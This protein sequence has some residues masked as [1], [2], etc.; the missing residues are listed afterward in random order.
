MGYLGWNY[1]GSPFS[2]DFTA[3]HLPLPLLTVFWV[4]FYNSSGF[5]RFCLFSFC[6]LVYGTTVTG[7]VDACRAYRTVSGTLRRHAA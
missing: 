5:Y 4:P 3:F 6:F 1:T 7:T 2:A